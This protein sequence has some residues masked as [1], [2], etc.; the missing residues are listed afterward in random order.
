MTRSLAILMFDDVE[1]L[2]ACGPFEVFSVANRITTRDGG[3]RAFDVVLVGVDD[4][5]VHA[6]GG[7]RIA[8]D[9]TIDDTRR[10]DVV[11]VPGG[12][13]D[14]VPAAAAAWI[15]TQFGTTEVTAS[16]CT[17]A[18]LLA[19][20]GVLDARPVTTHWEDV[21][22]LRRRWPSLDVREGV[23]YLDNG[24]IATSAGISAGLDLALHL[25]S[26]LVSPDVATSTARQMQYE[27]SDGQ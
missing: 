26:R 22:D 10:Y 15:H 12:V 1:V 20:A 11:L 14:E 21:D 7:M 8:V 19:D 24:D 5:P 6:R 13:V 23:R 25:V 4:G 9:T 16:V 27:W 3:V 17:G 2:D 18:F